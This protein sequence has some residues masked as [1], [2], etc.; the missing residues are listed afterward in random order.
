MSYPLKS[1]DTV[2]SRFCW[3]CLQ[4][5]LVLEFPSGEL[6]RDEEV[7]ELIYER[8]F[9]GHVTALPPPR[10]RLR[11]LK[12]LIAKIESSILDWDKYGI[13]ENLMGAL[14]QLLSQPLPT[15]TAA[16]QQRCHVTYRLSLLR[17]KP[18][19]SDPHIT[20]LESRSLISAS[21]TTGLRTWEAALHLGQ[22]LCVNPSVVKGKRVLELGAGT[23]Y[24]AVLCA[25]YLGASHVIASDGSEEV[26]G[27]LPDSFRLN[28]LQGSERISGTKLKWGHAVA[29]KEGQAWGGR[30]ELDTV[31]GADITYDASVIPALAETLVEMANLCRGISI[32]IAATERNQATFESFLNV[33]TQRGFS[34]SHEPFPVQPKGEQNGPFYN[35]ASPIH[36]CRLRM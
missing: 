3:Q 7:Q 26:V 8:L 21:G 4:L 15:E 35:D 29:D 13:S 36:I 6:L 2:I 18:A 23:G 22:Y 34:L 33:C 25:K 16:A 11:I 32:L 30:L 10:Y 20:L 1:V 12:D 28:G 14:T 17:P 24:L 31:I 5:E 19:V 9:A 27:K